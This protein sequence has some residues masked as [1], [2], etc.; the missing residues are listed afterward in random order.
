MRL[1]QREVQVIGQLHKNPNYPYGAMSIMLKA[2]SF[3]EFIGK[4]KLNTIAA[5]CIND[6]INQ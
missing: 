4:Y 6:F 5:I 2:L 1:L 3:S